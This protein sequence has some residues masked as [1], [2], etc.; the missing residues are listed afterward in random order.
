MVRKYGR[1]KETSLS[2]SHIF[3]KRRTGIV[4]SINVELQQNI[5]C[6]ILLDNMNCWTYY[7]DFRFYLS[8]F[9]LSIIKWTLNKRNKVVHVCIVIELVLMLFNFITY[10]ECIAYV[11]NFIFKFL[12]IYWIWNCIYLINIYNY[13]VIH[14]IFVN[15][16]II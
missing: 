11:F 15:I 7:N 1:D 6:L 10:F 14:W 4:V 16:R 12:R 3:F 8:L 2:I 13:W 5:Y 9:V